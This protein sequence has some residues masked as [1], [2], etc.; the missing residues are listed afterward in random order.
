MQLELWEL[1][2]CLWKQHGRVG[3]HLSMPTPPPGPPPPLPP[4]EPSSDA[5]P[6][7]APQPAS[8]GVG[9]APEAIGHASMTSPFRARG[10]HV[11]LPPSTAPAEPQLQLKWP[12]GRFFRG[13]KATKKWM[14]VL[15]VGEVR[16]ATA[17]ECVDVGWGWGVVG[18]AILRFNNP[19]FES[20]CCLT[21]A[22]TL[23]TPLGRR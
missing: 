8:N 4:G 13:V 23:T 9:G 12:S 17:A 2:V 16:P 14:R 1:R 10:P 18:V 3:G 19:G 20:R 22:G 11:R 21:P 15:D 7:R 5:T 6:R